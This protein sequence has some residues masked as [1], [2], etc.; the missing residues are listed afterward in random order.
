[1]TEEEAKGR[2]CPFAQVIH[3]SI[4]QDGSRHENGQ[5]AYNRIVDGS[6]YSFSKAGGCIASACM[7][8][9]WTT[10]HSIDGAI[11]YCGLAG[12]PR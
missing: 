10:K 1:M 11:G 2:W 8:W 6:A 4:G 5:T 7:A 12:A 3:G 9:R